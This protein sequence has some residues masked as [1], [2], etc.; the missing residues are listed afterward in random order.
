MITKCPSCEKKVKVP[1]EY[2]GKK[3]RCP[4][5]NNS[6][7][8]PGSRRKIIPQEVEEPQETASTSSLSLA[9]VALITAA[10]AGAVGFGGGMIVTRP[11]RTELNSKIEAAV[12]KVEDPLQNKIKA[13]EN[14]NAQLSAKLNSSQN[15][16]KR[17][18]SQL[19][20]SRNNTPTPRPQNTNYQ[21][22]SNNKLGRTGT[23]NKEMF[24][25]RLGESIQTLS[26]QFNVSRSTYT[27]TDKDHPGVIWNVE[28]PNPTVKEL[29]VSTY[30]DQI[31]EISVYFK[32]ASTTNYGVIRDQ[33][34]SKY[35]SKDEAG[36]V[37]DLFGEADYRVRIDGVLVYI[38]LNR[39]IGFEND[40]L[41]LEYSHGPI[42]NEMYK[43]VQQRKAQKVNNDL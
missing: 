24:G 32:D 17:T 3:C 34:A 42:S 21:P 12:S 29:R 20:S 5:C 40:T 14:Q 23:V 26:R 16:L 13:L 25:V 15:N 7:V 27:F 19:T 22:P 30:R 28:C 31:Y 18:K 37:G 6:F 9:L 41:E 43:E 36:F 4:G 11:Q 35:K 1:S 8:V 39:D 2:A 38:K 33:L 10:L